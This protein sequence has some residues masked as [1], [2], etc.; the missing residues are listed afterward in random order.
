MQQIQQRLPIDGGTPPQG[1]PPAIRVVRGADGGMRFADPNGNLLLH[2]KS[3]LEDPLPDW[4]IAERVR[5]LLQNP[6][7][8]IQ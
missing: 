3:D 4:G 5:A 1:P 8:R 7:S 2:P 6:D